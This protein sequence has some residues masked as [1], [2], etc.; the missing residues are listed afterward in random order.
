MNYKGGNE[1]SHLVPEA[2]YFLNNFEFSLGH[3][4][5]I[6]N[7]THKSLRQWRR[8]VFRVSV[9]HRG[10]RPNPRCKQKK[11]VDRY[12]QIIGSFKVTFGTDTLLVL[13]SDFVRLRLAQVRGEKG[14]LRVR[15]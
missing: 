4:P 5:Y 1:K 8:G 11:T 3:Q 15:L 9:C 7:K 12:C 14:A 2:I 13:S 6:M 10:V